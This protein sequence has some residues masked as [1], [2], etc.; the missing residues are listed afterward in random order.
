MDLSIRLGEALALSP[1]FFS[2]AQL[3]Y[4]L[5]IESQKQRRKIRPLAA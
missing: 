3:Q 5:W 2:K 4:D 1:D